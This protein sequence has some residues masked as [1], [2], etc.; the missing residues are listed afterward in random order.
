MRWSESI[1]LALGE[2]RCSPRTGQSMEE[3]VARRIH[4]TIRDDCHGG[5]LHRRPAGG[6]ADARFREAPTY[7]LGGVVCYS[8]DLKTA[9]VDVPA[10]IIESQRRG[11]RGSGGG[12]GRRN[13]PPHRRDAGRRN[14]RHRRSQRRHAGKAGGPRAYRLGGRVRQ[15][16]ARV[17]LSRRPRPHALAGFATALDMVRRYFLYAARR[18][19][20]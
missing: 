5:K 13:S 3:V 7:F 20:G 16:G 15:Q 17:A 4:A 1:S 11:Q 14:H 2:S 6:A 12:A 8:N 10:E 9:W 19:K 18:P